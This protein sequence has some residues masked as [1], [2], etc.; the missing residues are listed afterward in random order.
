MAQEISRM[1]LAQLQMQASLGVL[2]QANHQPEI[3]L[4]LLDFGSS[5]D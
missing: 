2:A 5:S 4:R 1:V 3:A